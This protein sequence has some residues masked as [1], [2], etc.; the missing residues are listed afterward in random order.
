MQEM[1]WFRVNEFNLFVPGVH[2][3]RGA[4]YTEEQGFLS[5]YVAFFKGNPNMLFLFFNQ[6][7]KICFKQGS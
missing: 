1:L 2:A 3:P 4:K 7:N 6:P 5:R